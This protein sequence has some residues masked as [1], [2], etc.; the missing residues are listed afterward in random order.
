MLGYSDSAKDVGVV[1]ARRGS[2]IARRRA[3]AAARE[4][5]TASRSRCSTAAA[6]RSAAAAARRSI[7][8]LTALPPGTVGGRIKITE[9]GEIISQKFGL[10]SIAERS[11]EV[12][13]TGTLMAAFR[14]LRTDLDAR[15]VERFR[16]AMDELAETSRRAFRQHGPRRSRALFELFLSA[17]PVRELTHVHFGSRPAYRER[18]AGTM[19]GIRAIPW[20]F[21]WTQMRL[22]A[23]GL[24]RRRHG[25]GRDAREARRPRALA[26]RWRRTGRSSIDLLDKLEMVLR[27]GR[28]RHRAPVRESS[29]RR[30]ERHGRARGRLRA[31]RCRACTASASAS[32]S[33]TTASCRARWGF[34]ILT[35]TR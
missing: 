11:L 6:A 17:T 19:A 10:P 22:M 34:G 29:G 7:R 32:S 14:D 16:E 25:A 9:Q 33:A 1:S 2:S 12:M 13:L 3:C 30:R 35:S 26:A 15:T 5:R 18:G 20:N 27:Q 4:A 8:A 21:G 31:R 28:P 23:I 24:A